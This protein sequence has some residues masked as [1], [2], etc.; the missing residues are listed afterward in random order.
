MLAAICEHGMP[1]ASITFHAGAT[2]APSKRA[3]WDATITQIL[4]SCY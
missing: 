1:I 2:R 4:A 3:L